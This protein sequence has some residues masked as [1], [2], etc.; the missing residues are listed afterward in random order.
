MKM[1]NAVD[2]ETLQELALLQLELKKRQLFSA[3]RWRQRVETCLAAS[4][5]GFNEWLLLDA[6]WERMDRTGD[7]VSENELA[8][9]L[10]L[11]S[12]TI[13]HA[14]AVLDHQGLVSR[15]CSMSGKAWRVFVTGKGADLLRALEPAL[16]R[17]SVA[18]P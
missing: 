2:T 16:E 15:G 5:I 10:E 4:G 14:M 18:S 11:D 12:M 6:I 1:V 3:L 13:W 17:A 8:R 7:A 9:D